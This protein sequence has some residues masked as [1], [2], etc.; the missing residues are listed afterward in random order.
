MA[1]VSRAN[2]KALLGKKLGM[3]QIFQED[4]KW[5]PVTVLEV[6][7]C[8]V[9][10]VKSTERDGYTAY[11]LG[12]DDRRKSAK[13]PQQS[14]YERIGVTTKRFVR[15][16]PYIDG[17]DLKASSP[18]E[19]SSD[20]GS[21]DV[22]EDGVSADGGSADGGAA[23]GGAADG[24]GDAGSGDE[25]DQEGVARAGSRISVSI[26]RGI[27]RV[28]VQGVTKGRGFTGTVKRYGF[29]TGD[30]SHGGKSVREPGSTGQH[31]DPGRVFKGK[32]MA[33]HHGHANRKARNLKVVEIDE[34]NHLLLVRGSV[35]GPTGGY[36]TIE[37]S[38]S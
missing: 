21:D 17:E 33:G 37:E 30:E 15:E 12:F 10:Q 18:E 38:L 2:K 31:T 3:T 7:P 27:E 25:G 6:G 23:D 4:G 13:R 26:F 36:V 14:L 20:D 28:D 1:G 16:I 22:S 9:L 8:F 5:I 24:E 34:E 35:P 11:Q 29:R 32:R 19:A